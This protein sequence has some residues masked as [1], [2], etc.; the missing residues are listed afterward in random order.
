MEFKLELEGTGDSRARPKWPIL[1]QDL[2]ATGP[3]LG[4]SYYRPLIFDVPM[5]WLDP[6]ISE[7]FYLQVLM[8]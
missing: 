8:Y 4:S 5:P 7:A 6:N 2:H 3:S 1:G